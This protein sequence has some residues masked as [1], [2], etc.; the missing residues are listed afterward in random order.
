MPSRRGGAAA[1]AVLMLAF[2]A[3]A[4]H[5]ATDP[6]DFAQI[7]RGRYL[8]IVGDCAACHTNA[9]GPPYA[10]GRPIETP[11]GTVV[12]PNITPD[13]ATGIGAWSDDAF[14]SAVKDGIGR[15]GT[16]LYP[17]MPYPY[18]TRATGQDVLDIRAFLNTVPA[19][20]NAVRA[21]QLPFP[22]DIRAGMIAWNALFF[23]RGTFAPDP[24]KSAE[25]NRGAYLAEG[26]MHCGAC[27]TPKNL[28]GGDKASEAGQGYALQ[29]WFAP[30]ITNAAGRGLGAWSV[31]D[32]VAY[33][34][35][36][37]NRTAAATGPMADE[38][39]DSSSKMSDADLHA[40]AVYLKDQPAPH[41]ATPQPLAS[42]DPAMTAGAAVYRD[43]C[44]A[45]HAPQGSGVAGLFPG[46]AG[47]PAVQSRDPTSL[48]RVVL[49]GARSA[50]TDPAP[51]GPAMPAFGWLLDD[52]EIAAVLTYVRNSWGNAASAVS[53]G[54]VAKRRSAVAERVE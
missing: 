33:L 28:A 5:G 49:A 52:R 3:G 37:H 40:V 50:A 6:Q 32:I 18:F 15:D 13:A 17:A 14:V 41:E 2:G 54:E 27:H 30:D 34:K 39:A 26:L 43:E 31:E 1:L 44:S 51:T 25:W 45:C 47:A 8:V 29:G 12:A 42:S 20:R 46:L 22:F 9:G 35:T 16:H 36:G 7:A 11:F 48:L 21:N 19:V 53:S 24:G 23:R 4:A 38:V 10:G